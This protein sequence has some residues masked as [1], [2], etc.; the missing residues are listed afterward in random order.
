VSKK[1]IK[2]T[3]FH[4]TLIYTGGGERIVLGQLEELRKRG[5]ETACF[6]PVIDRDKC[7]PDIIDKYCVGSLL[8][9]LPSWFPFRHAVLLVATSLLMPVLALRFRDTDLF[10]GEN[11][12][13]TWMAFVAAKVLGKPYL[14][15]TCHPNKMLYPRR[16]SREQIW[17]N[18]RDFYWLSVLFEPFKPILRLL[19]RW[20]FTGSRFPVLTNGFF[21]GREFGRIYKTAWTACPSG[22]PAL[23]PRLI[24]KGKE[25][26][27]EL[28]LGDQKISKPYLLFVGRHEVWKRLDLAVRVMAKIK[29]KVPRAS[30]VIPGPYT[31]H[32]Y[33]LIK[34]AEK[35]GVNDRVLFIGEV[36]QGEL[37]ELY[38]NAHQFI[39]PSVKEDFGIVILE[40]MGNGLPVVAWKAGGP[41]DM[42][43][44][45]ENGFLARPFEVDDF[46]AKAV[47]LLKNPRLR[48]KLGRKG[49]EKVRHEFS[50]KKH[51]DIL[52]KSI[53]EMLGRL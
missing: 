1:K 33:D 52:E 45:G 9:Q 25:K 23:P 28:I 50:W 20:S 30:L 14:I 37:A 48:D 26:S 49:W 38:R 2:I 13:G 51:A 15:Y 46:A 32:T 40:A 42:V 22:A 39:F 53:K 27:G 36:D 44:D 8:P 18:E 43:A 16:L 35:L 29:V 6:V 12:P 11:Q 34:L 7:Y 24:D 5:Y 41:T 31:S 10:I 4:C 17:Q 47:K 3:I 19:D 21:I